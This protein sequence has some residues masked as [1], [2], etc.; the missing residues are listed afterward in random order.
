MKNNNKKKGNLFP[1]ALITIY[2]RTPAV[3]FQDWSS[4]NLTF[5]GIRFFFFFCHPSIS[6]LCTRLLG[7]CH[8]CH[9]RLLL[10]HS[11][12]EPL[13]YW[14]F[15]RHLASAIYIVAKCRH[16]FISVISPSVP[17]RSLILMWLMLQSRPFIYTSR[18]RVEKFKFVFV[19]PLHVAATLFCPVFI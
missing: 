15:I 14:W 12:E 5:R 10:E 9:A 6:P 2:F 16:I 11:A 1:N 3:T 8:R 19:R 18:G 4:Y 7:V 13:G 17:K